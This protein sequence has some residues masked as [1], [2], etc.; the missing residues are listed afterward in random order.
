MKLT[1]KLNYDVLQGILKY[2][3]NNIEEIPQQELVEEQKEEYEDDY[4]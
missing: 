3:N 4:L 2:D 1:K